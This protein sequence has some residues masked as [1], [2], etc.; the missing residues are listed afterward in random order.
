MIDIT[1]YVLGYKKV[2]NNTLS[3]EK[4]LSLFGEIFSKNYNAICLDIDKTIT[5]DHD[6]D[7][8]MLEI[9]KNLLQ[10]NISLCFITGRGRTSSKEVLLQ[11]F[12]YMKKNKVD[13]KNI[14]CA[15]SNGITFLQSNKEFLDEE[16]YIVSKIKLEEY[17][18]IKNEIREHYIK[19]LIKCGGV[20]AN[21]KELIERSINCTGNLNLRFAF[22]SKE[23]IDNN[24]MTSTL[25]DI[26]LKTDLADELNVFK[27]RHKDKIIYEVSM[28]DKLK[29]IEYFSKI[30]NISIENI[31]KI[32]DQANK[33]GNDFSMLNTDAGFSVDE[34][35]KNEIK[36][37]PVINEK[38][39]Q[40]KGIKATKKIIKELNFLEKE[41]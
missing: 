3:E 6:I 28:T 33:Y 5:D 31:V 11:I 34:I 39:E 24:I 15:T 29:A 18:Y 25:K 8:E 22:N 27:G 16:K 38:C 41:R 32:G 35:D 9:F 26:V 7:E 12:N 14:T 1:K 36:I 4:I 17:L 13:I 40:E 19:E 23:I 37:L 10:K 21:I 30:K 2:K 20:N